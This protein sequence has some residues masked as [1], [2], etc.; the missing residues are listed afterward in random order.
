MKADTVKD[1]MEW[2]APKVQEIIG[3]NILHPGG[4][5]V[6]FGRWGTWKSML[7]IHLAFCVSR[8]REWVSFSTSQAPVLMSQVEI[9]KIM[10]KRRLEKYTSSMGR[11]PENLWFLSEAY[12][13]IDKEYSFKQFETIVAV[14]RPKLLILDPIYKLF[15]GDI[16]DNT[17]VLRMLDKLDRLADRFNLSIMVIGHVRKPNLRDDG[18]VPDLGHELIGGS[19]IMDWVDTA[20]AVEQVSDVVLNLHFVKVRHAEEDIGI[21]QVRVSREDLHF[22]RTDP[23]GGSSAEGVQNQG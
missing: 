5:M 19:Y 14:T 7:A 6:M 23:G 10:L 11:Y 13:R 15:G 20:V 16:S 1:L 2:E 12:L 22:T 17:Q 8:G 18:S 4:R 9:P 3:N 21:V